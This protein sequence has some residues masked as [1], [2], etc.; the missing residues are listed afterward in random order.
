[1]NILQ[2][3]SS[4]RTS[5]AEKHVLVLS[6]R[7][8]QRGHQVVA[9]CPP[10][11]WL[12]EQ[13]RAAGIPTLEL[14]MRGLSACAVPMNLTRFLREHRI[15]LIHAHLTRATY[16]GLLA[17][18]LARLPLVSSIH[19]RTHDVA[20]RY[21]FP[22]HNSR[23]VAVSDFLKNGLLRK[24]VPESRIRTIYNGT[25][26]LEETA[27][28]S[29][30][31]DAEVLPVRAELSLPPDAELVGLIARVEEFKG[32]LVLARAVQRIV[33]ARPRAYFVCVGPVVPQVQR[34]IWEITGAA[35]VAERLRFTGMRDDVRRLMSDM[36]V[37]TLPSRYEAC[38]MSIIEGMA[39]GKP[40]VATR[41]GGNP[42]LIAHDETGLLIERT[43]EAL[44]DAL[45]AVLA[46]P[47]RRQ[48]MGEAARE[49]AQ[50]RFS[51]RVMVDQIEDLYCEILQSR[52]A[53]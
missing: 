2:L 39:M 13:L 47:E 23:I 16:F 48:R 53:A 49:R 21:L 31:G 36:D 25:E 33:E 17:G 4:S 41:A 52:A 10:R 42:E 5:G 19:C 38:S 40:V 32:H 44:A 35:G 51:A 26:F 43:P 50:T 15:D 7:L 8:R 22:R 29:A 18:R 45:I 34:E 11:D 27:A 30:E 28:K 3:V 37:L 24:G 6:E 46:D 20:Y 14:D 12:P 1:M 9:V